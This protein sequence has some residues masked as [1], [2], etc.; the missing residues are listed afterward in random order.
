M[1]DAHTH[2]L[3]PITGPSIVNVR[4][5]VDEVSVEHNLFSVGIHPWDSHL[6][7][8]MVMF[9]QVAQKAV[10][11]G[12]CGLDKN[13]TATMQQQIAVFEQQIEVAISLGKPI[14]VHCVRA[15]GMLLSII[16]K[17]GSQVKWLIHGCYASTEWIA[18]AA[19]YNVYFSVGP[20]QL[21][22]PRITEV[23]QAIP[24][25]RLLLET[26]DSGKALSD[27][28]AAVNVSEDIVDNNFYNFFGL[29]LNS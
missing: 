11:I 5:G 10:A 9:A 12:E 26:D 25:E 20:K 2:Q 3:L 4:Y 15:Y 8:N 19:K 18:A 27:I 17:H 24:T 6:S 29:T 7:H 13:A 23:L 21:I 14:I 22:L 28:V 16:Q 1:T